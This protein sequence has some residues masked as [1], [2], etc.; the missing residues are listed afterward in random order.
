[1]SFDGIPNFR[2]YSLTDIHEFD[3]CVFRFLVR[4]HLEKKKEIDDSNPAMALGTL[5]DESI[6][7]FHLTNGY[8]LGEGYILNAV[9]GAFGHIQDSVNT[10]KEKSFYFKHIE[11]MTPELI[12]KAVE[13]F[14]SYHR[15]LGGKIKK[16]LCQVDF[17]SYTL[18]HPT[19]PVKLWGLPD[20]FEIGEDGVIEVVDYKYHENPVKG[21]AR[22]DM[23]MMPKIYVLLTAKFL[24]S[25][26]FERARFVVRLWSDPA[27]DSFQEEYDLLHLD[28]TISAI[29]KKLDPILQNTNISFCERQYCRACK[30]EKRLEYLSAIQEEFQMQILEDL[31]KTPDSQMTSGQL[32]TQD[33]DT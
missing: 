16:S 6:K 13:V 18:V 10:K 14:K 12:E 29:L 27:N 2:A 1:M 19:G 24:L 3:S 4:H 30:S 17:C 33:I 26:G 21:A 5:L 7:R 8:D 9:M 22:L 15:G 11:F 31:I 32:I 28:N 25:R 20:T 23:D